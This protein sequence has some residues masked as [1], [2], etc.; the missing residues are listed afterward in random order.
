VRRSVLLVPVLAMA[1]VGTQACS[2]S[3]N[4]LAVPGTTTATSEQAPTTNET[5][6]TST[7]SPSSN[8]SPLVDKDP[9]P[10][11][12][13]SAQ[14]KLGV[15]GGQ[16][17]DVGSGRGCQWTVRG[18]QETDFYVVQIY[19]H[20]GLKD[21]PSD[22]KPKQLPDVGKHK[23]VQTSENGSVNMGVTD[24]SQVST[25]VLTGT[26]TQKACDLAMQMARLVEPE[27]P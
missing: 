15:S 18:P 20:S 19:D 26:D 1:F 4:G 9:C 17:H 16:R 27:L 8:E 25:T 22:S 21:I 7:S 23:A 10:L 6:E 3:T 14:A 5:S 12:T 24:T 13:A 11:L 2:N